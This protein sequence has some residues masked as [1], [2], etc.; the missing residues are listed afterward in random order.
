MNIHMYQLT[1][2]ER[3]QMKVSREGKNFIPIMMSEILQLKQQ[4]V[5]G[6]GSG[7]IGRNKF[8]RIKRIIVTKEI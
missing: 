8:L 7:Y 3:G 4:N 1:G 5:K 2:R 6:R